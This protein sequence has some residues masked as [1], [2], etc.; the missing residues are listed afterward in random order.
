L[1]LR[2]VRE[3]LLALSPLAFG[4]IW[5]AGFMWVFDLQFN[6]GNIFGLPLILGAGAEYGLSIVTRFMEDR[7]H[8]GP[9]IAR[10]TVMG[11]LIAALTTLVGFASLMLAD[12]RGIYGLGLLLTIGTITSMIAA[13]IV[14]PVLLRLCYRPARPVMVETPEPSETLQA[15]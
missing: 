10:S 4:L 8:G 6:L 1:M 9:L 5:T 12:H 14:L 2:R 3:T 15:R 7:E 11:V 13:L